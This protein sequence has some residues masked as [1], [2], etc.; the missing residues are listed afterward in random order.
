MRKEDVFAFAYRKF[1]QLGFR[2][3]GRGGKLKEAH[4][5]RQYSHPAAADDSPTAGRD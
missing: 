4:P 2:C 5:R 1:H 3:A